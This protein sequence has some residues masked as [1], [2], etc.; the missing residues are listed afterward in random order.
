MLEEF[1]WD[2]SFGELQGGFLIGSQFERC[3][4]GVVPLG[5]CDFEDYFS[6]YLDSEGSSGY[7]EEPNFWEDG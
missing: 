1:F 6:E 5:S 4:D 7:M 3:P 2:D